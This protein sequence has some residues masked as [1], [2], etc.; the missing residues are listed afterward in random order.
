MTPNAKSLASVSLDAD[1]LWSYLKTHG[2]ASWRDYPSYLDRLFSIS[3]DTLEALGLRCTFFIVGRDAADA[4]HSDALADLTRRGHGVGNHTFEHEPWLHRYTPQQLVDEIARAEEAIER[5]TGQRPIGFRGPGFSWTPTVL[6]VLAERGYQ[7]DAS[8]FP[9]FL[10]PLARAYY[11]WTASLNELQR[12]ERSS[13][14]GGWRDVLNPID[15][16]RWRLSGERTLLEIPVT[17][18]PLLRTPFHLSYLLYLGTRSEALA[19]GY[20]RTAIALCH[21]TRV[22]PSILLHPLDFLGG[23]EE[24]NLAFFPAMRMPGARK[25]E[26]AS[27]LLKEIT[28]AFDVLPLDVYARA[29]SARATLRVRTPNGSPNTTTHAAK[30]TLHQDQPMGDVIG[31]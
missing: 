14:F 16:Y 10:G 17:T 18:C 11:F 26:L 6:H 23:D 22:E 28:T 5:A 27:R 25:R 19:L 29:I 9:T 21:A 7:Y 3:M 20:L 13:L 15:P 31:S 24:P 8:T 2:D 4:R 1:N 12:E 30:A